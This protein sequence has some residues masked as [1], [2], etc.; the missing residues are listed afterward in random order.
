[1]I[2]PGSGAVRDEEICAL[3]DECLD[4][5]LETLGRWYNVSFSCEGF[6]ARALHFT[7]H[8]EKYEDI[9][10][11]LGA[12]HRIAGVQFDINGRHVHVRK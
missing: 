7:G 6:D 3:Y 9:N 2:E 11:I 1:M 12:I 5:V 4:E 10:V 8:M